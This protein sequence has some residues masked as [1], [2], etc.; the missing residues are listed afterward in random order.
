M[1]THTDKTKKDNR[2]RAASASLQ[3]RRPNGCG[4]QFQDN[5]SDAMTQARL[6]DLANNRSQTNHTGLPNNLKSGIENLSGYSM[7][8]VKVHYNSSRP[9]QLNAQAYAQGTDI[10]LAP[11]QEQHLPHET[12]HVVQQKQGRVK[13]TLQM[14]EIISVNDDPVLEKEADVM[15]AKSLSLAA[16]FSETGSY[17]P[18]K[19]AE[20]TL[21]TT[22]QCK[23][24]EVAGGLFKDDCGDG[25]IPFN[26]ESDDQFDQRGGQMSQLEFRPNINLTNKFGQRAKEV[27]LVQTTR[28]SVK[29]KHQVGEAED[30]PESLLNE[31]RTQAGSAI[32]Q[33]IYLKVGKTAICDLRRT[34]LTP[35]INAMMNKGSNAYTNNLL[36]ALQKKIMAGSFDRLSQI[37]MNILKTKLQNIFKAEGANPATEIEE[38]V[39]KAITVVENSRKTVNLDPR[40]AEERSSTYG[41]MKPS[42]VSGTIAKD[43]TGWNATRSLGHKAWQAAAVLRDRP[44]HT[45]TKNTELEG[46]EVFEVAAMADGGKFVGSIRWGWKIDGT[47][48][49]RV[50]QEIEIVNHG[51]ASDEFYQAAQKWN[52]MTVPD[53]DGKTPLTTMQLPE[54]DPLR[55]VLDKLGQALDEFPQSPYD[56]KPDQTEAIQHLLENLK[57]SWNKLKTEQRAQSAGAMMAHVDRYYLVVEKRRPSQTIMLAEKGFVA[58]PP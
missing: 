31:R 17:L 35:I 20:V 51:E 27:S 19:S 11:G 54:K 44:A 14:K 12:W 57:T 39:P 49:E 8:D 23:E 18:E 36:T 9:A 5:R 26:D 34:E 40:Y 32:D 3:K 33:Q 43:T 21:A 58:I 52:E 25:Y 42:E 24:I 29:Q 56:V 46:Q 16:Q 53:L 30:Q 22:V 10:H 1:N 13:P 38:N 4:F 15:G 55:P 45:V 50:N 37:K 48:A 47:V 2:Q 7:D 28:S 6:Q 41:A